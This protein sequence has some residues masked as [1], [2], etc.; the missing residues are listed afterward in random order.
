MEEEIIIKKQSKKE[1]VIKVEF[2]DETGHQI[3]MLKPQETIDLIEN[4]SSNWVFIDD[5]FVEYE[6]ID[7]V[8]WNEA[9]SVRILPALVGGMTNKL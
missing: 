7:E 4:N 8:D 5:K 3:L 1:K 2:A 6:F 9:E